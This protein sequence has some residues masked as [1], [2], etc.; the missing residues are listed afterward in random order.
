MELTIDNLYDMNKYLSDDTKEWILEKIKTE[1][2][3]ESLYKDSERL[4]NILLENEKCTDIS[5]FNIYKYG[6]F[7]YTYNGKLVAINVVNER[8]VEVRIDN[9]CY[10]TD[11]IEDVIKV[12]PDIHM[13]ME[14]GII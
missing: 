1:K 5:R 10:G 3:K 4:Y 11:S 13:A 9:Y 6:D 2:K 14:K 7:R 12:L 8:T